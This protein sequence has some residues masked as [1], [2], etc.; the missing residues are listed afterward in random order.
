[1]SEVKDEK[2]EASGGSDKHSK[3]SKKDKL[4]DPN[5]KEGAMEKAKKNLASKAAT[6]SLGKKILTKVMD[7][8]SNNLMK[9]VKK[10]IEFQSDRKKAKEIQNNIIRMLVKAQHQMDVKKLTEAELV[11]VDRPL[12]KAFRRLVRINASWPQIKSDPNQINENFSALKIHL[13]EIEVM[14]L[15]VLSP[16]LSEKNKTKFSA[17][18]D[19]LSDIEFLKK[20]WND[21]RSKPEIEKMC[22]AMNNYL[23][24]PSRAP[25][26]DKK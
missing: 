2:K 22:K 17:T 10:I 25:K 26:S 5:N 7:D 4:L 13:K 1:M 3:H 6:S 19:Y 15:G 14:I 16:F 8:Q 21:E 20:V 23:K 9:A 11:G 18:F 12:R 24:N